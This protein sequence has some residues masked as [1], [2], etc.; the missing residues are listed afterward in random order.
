MTHPTWYC[1]YFSCGPGLTLIVVHLENEDDVGNDKATIKGCYFADFGMFLYRKEA[2]L[3]EEEVEKVERNEEGW[4][5]TVEVWEE[6]CEDLG[7]TDSHA[8]IVFGLLRTD[9]IH[10][11][12]RKLSE[13]VYNF[14]KKELDYE[15]VVE[16]GEGFFVSIYYYENEERTD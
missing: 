6:T 8:F 15:L 1:S 5:K 4:G 3:F 9:E 14:W 2:T 11:H 7:K 16:G 10:E 13:V 12:W